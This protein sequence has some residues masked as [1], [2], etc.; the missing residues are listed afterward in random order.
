MSV[1]DDKTIKTWSV[2]EGQWSDVP[3]DTVISK[4]MVTCLSHAS[5]GDTFATCGEA[6]QLWTRGRHVPSRT[7]QWGVDTVHHVRFNPVEKHLLGAA[8]SDRSIILYDT[9]E[10]GPVRKVVMNLKTNCISWNPM[11]AMVFTA[12]NEDYNLYTFDVRKLDRPTN[13]LMDHVGAVVDVDYSPTGKE[14]VSGSYDKT[15]RLWNVDQGRSRDVYNN[16]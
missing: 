16:I 1:G 11:E 12:A 2:G 10:V 13:V 9:R 7:F 8:S 4:H 15:V 6:T 5:S 3:T 14:L